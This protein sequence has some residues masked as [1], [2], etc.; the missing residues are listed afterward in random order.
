MLIWVRTC[1]VPVEFTP[2]WRVEFLCFGLSRTVIVSF[3][4][5]PMAFLIYRKS[6]TLAENLLTIARFFGCRCFCFFCILPHVQK[7]T[8]CGSC[9]LVCRW[10]C[11]ET[12]RARDR[13]FALMDMLS[14]KIKRAEWPP[15]QGESGRG[16][17]GMKRCPHRYSLLNHLIWQPGT[18]LH[19]VFVCEN[20]AGAKSK[21]VEQR[22][23]G[24]HFH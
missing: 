7:V 20:G 14:M 15:R 11:T 24:E 16:E 23:S 21:E 2:G 17:W 1:C 4:A 18:K 13:V 3:D 6:D 22:R 8:L 12:E 19:R 10:S 5:W 9:W